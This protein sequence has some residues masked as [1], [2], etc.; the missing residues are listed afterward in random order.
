MK[1]DNKSKFDP[2]LDRYKSQVSS[3]RPQGGQDQQ[4]AKTSSP[5]VEGAAQVEI[6]ARGRELATNNV[7]RTEVVDRL[8]AEVE[9]GTFKPDPQKI[10]IGMVNASM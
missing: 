9:S 6:S 7:V 10:A 4:Q 1:V 3:V 2:R 8:K 5:K